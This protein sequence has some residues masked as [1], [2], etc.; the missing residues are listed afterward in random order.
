MRATERTSSKAASNAS[1]LPS[2]GA[3]DRAGA[4]ARRAARR[5]RI[6]IPFSLWML[7]TASA[8]VALHLAGCWPLNYSEDCED[9]AR[10]CPPPTGTGGTGGT[11]PTCDADPTQDASTVT[12]RCAVFA[13]AGA[14]SGGDG[15][16]VSPYA[17]LA[18]AIANANGKRVLAC[19]SGA[20]AES[21]TIKAAVEVIGGFDCTAGWT[22]SDQSRSAIEGPADKVALTLAGDASGVKLQNFTIRAADATEPGGS[23][24][25]VAVDDIE[26]ELVR[27]D[28][29]AGDG[30]DGARGETPGPAQGGASAPADVSNAC[31]GAVYGG[32]PGK[33]TCDDGETSGGVGGLGGKPEENEGLGQN[34]Q[35]GT[36]QA[37][38][39]TQHGLGGVGHGQDNASDDCGSGENGARGANGGPG[40]GGSETR[41][42]LASIAGGDGSRG[43]NGVRGQGGG[44]G[45]GAKSGP[46]CS[47]GGGTFTDGAGASGGGG[48]AGGCGGRGGGGGKAGG[49]SIAIV[50][51]GTQLVLTDVTVAVGKAGNGGTGGDGSAG[52]AGGTGSEGGNRVLVSGSIEGCT[53]GRGGAGGD[54]G[55]GGGGRGGHAVGIAYK[56][57]PSPAPAEVPFEGGPAGD[58][59]PPGF[60]GG[61][62]SAGA[63]GVTGACW[64]FATNTTCAPQ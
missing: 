64:D 5:R 1:P 63:P 30:S 49:S 60:G 61:E 52:G 46:F 3:Q 62:T 58:G 41:L 54:G 4:P 16:K 9:D 38:P 48:G 14:A 31:V 45:G 27:V 23:S 50:S 53:G 10:Y 11:D 6:G 55:P 39:P 47:L 59:G 22:W 56:V 37:V 34:G 21:V 51:L 20:F 35:A 18:E 8:V 29:I 36:P 26:A 40:T 19:S 25:G 28:V 2:G 24:I 43:I 12:D 32:L 17:T 44:G 33:T 7:P 15:T 13:S 57:T 42:M